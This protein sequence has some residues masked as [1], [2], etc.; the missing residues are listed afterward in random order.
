MVDFS[1]ANLSF[2]GCGFMCVYHAGVCAA[3]K[4]HLLKNLSNNHNF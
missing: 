4:G 1:K 3:L 2:A